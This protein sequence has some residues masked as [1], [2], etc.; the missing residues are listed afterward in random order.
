MVTTTIEVT[1]DPPD[2]LE[3]MARY[4]NVFHEEMSKTATQAL[5]HVQGSVPDYPP[6]P[7]NSSYRRT[8]TLGRSMGLAGAKA[9]ISQVKRSG[10]V[11]TA[12]L[13]T[14]LEYAPQVIG[15][16]TQ[17]PR[18]RHWWTTMSIANAAA[19]GIERLYRLSAQRMANFLEGS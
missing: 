9:D 14:R 16:E 11:Y 2:L 8:L 6:P 15:E 4:P 12:T 13:G 10:R 3:R 19:A 7:E 18:M 1:Y 5:L 17:I